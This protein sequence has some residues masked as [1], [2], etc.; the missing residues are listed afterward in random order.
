MS[1]PREFWIVEAHGD[2]YYDSGER[3]FDTKQNDYPAPVI[4]VIEKSAY[5]QLVYELDKTRTEHVAKYD[6]LEKAAL[7]LRESLTQIAV[8][9]DIGPYE[10]I[11]GCNMAKQAIAEFDKAMKEDGD[12]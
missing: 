8:L 6:R 2:D 4:N 11:R 12:E 9:N 3:V 1:K 7:K 10:A 5:N